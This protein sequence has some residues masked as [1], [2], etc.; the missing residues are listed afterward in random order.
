MHYEYVT[1]S[2]GKV[3]DSGWLAQRVGG[4]P[5]EQKMLK[6]HL[7]KVIYHLVYQH[8]KS[9]SSQITLSINGGLHRARL[10][11]YLAHKKADN[12][13]P[14]RTLAR[15]FVPRSRLDQKF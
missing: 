6:G 12:K 11:G 2:W 10:Q 1:Q 7:T 13:K 14:D 4:L 9:T 3:M 15:P 8:T 5:R